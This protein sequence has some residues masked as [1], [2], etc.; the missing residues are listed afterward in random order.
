MT[1]PTA[2]A[3]FLLFPRFVYQ[4]VLL[5]PTHDPDSSPASPGASFLPCNTWTAHT[6]RGLNNLTPPNSFVVS[7]VLN[8]SFV[9][10][11]SRGFSPLPGLPLLKTYLLSS[12]HY[13]RRCFV[14]YLYLLLCFMLHLYLGVVLI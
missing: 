13:P 5:S 3:P 4:R 11:L 7:G 6:A 8:G 14:R 10:P 1:S 9:T 12:Y 2:L